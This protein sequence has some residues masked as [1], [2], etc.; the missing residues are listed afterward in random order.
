M[1][2]LLSR[3]KPYRFC[4]FLL[5]ELYKLDELEKSNH[6][7]PPPYPRR[8]KPLWFSFLTLLT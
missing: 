7:L 5:D 8:G 1:T 2:L 3:G 6:P 4:F